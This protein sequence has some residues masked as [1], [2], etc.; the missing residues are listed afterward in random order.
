[1]PQNLPST[2]AST[3]ARQDTGNTYLQT[4]SSQLPT[5]GSLFFITPTALS[6]DAAL[7]I[8]GRPQKVFRTGFSKTLLGVV[9]TSSFSI[10]YQGSGS[11]ISQSLGN[12]IINAGTVKSSEVIIRSNQNW[13][14]AWNLRYQLSL[15]Q[16]IANNNFFVEMVDVIG[17]NLPFTILNTRSLQVTIPNNLFDSTN[18][19]QS[20]YIGAFTGSDTNITASIPGRYSIISTSG[21]TVTFNSVFSQSMS[22]SVG[23]CSLFGWNYYHLLYS[24][25]TATNV[26]F[27]SQRC[28]WNTGDTTTAINTTVTAGHMGL[29]YVEDVLANYLDQPLTSAATYQPISRA[30]RVTNIPANDTNLY[31]QIRSQNGS[32]SPASNTSMSLGYISLED[33]SPLPVSIQSSK[34]SGPNSA[35]LSQ[36]IQNTAAN[37]NATVTMVSSASNVNQVATYPVAVMTVASA[38]LSRGVGALGTYL[39]PPS[40]NNMTEVPL[41]SRT[42]S[43]TTS[44][45]TFTP[46]ASA[47]GGYISALVNSISITGSVSTGGIDIQ[48]QESYDDGINWMDSYHFERITTSSMGA[49][50][51]TTVWMPPIPQS[52]RRRWVFQQPPILTSNFSITTMASSVS[53]PMFR[54]Y[55]DRTPS[56]LDGSLNSSSAAYNITGCKMVNATI[57]L[58][59]SLRSGSIYQLQVSNDN[60]SWVTVG[61]GVTASLTPSLISSTGNIARLARVL[62]SASGSAQTGSYVCITG[63]N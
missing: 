46:V 36:V 63:T 44:Y 42:G 51:A 40:S 3:A 60:S 50:P 10:I 19:S 23:S 59:G 17:D 41:L 34:N 38:A 26:N 30:S 13:N 16:R 56:L 7:P 15:S 22:G 43:L 6:T 25:S 53:Q 8:T 11:S 55:F 57:V 9:D 27:D 58:S 33:F 14:G 21:S 18:I 62:V 52:G 29:L 37:L 61:T 45:V 12:L 24:G 35:I 48:L 54:Q 2:V 47:V 28:G 4:I 32:I 49:S 1:M 39:V 31:I 5:T 20:M